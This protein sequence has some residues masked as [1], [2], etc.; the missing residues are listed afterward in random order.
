MNIEFTKRYN[1]SFNK[2][3]SNYNEKSAGIGHY[4]IPMIILIVILQIMEVVEFISIDFKTVLIVYL[5]LIS[6]YFS[7]NIW[8]KNNIIYQTSKYA[9]Y[10]IYIPFIVYLI[11]S[12]IS[13]NILVKHVDMNLSEI[14]KISYYTMAALSVIIIFYAIGNKSNIEKAF[15]NIHYRLSII[16]L[17]YLYNLDY[18]CLDEFDEKCVLVEKM[19]VTCLEIKQLYT[20]KELEL[21]NKILDDVKLLIA[22]KKK[23]KDI[24][25]YIDWLRKELVNQTKVV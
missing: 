8:I 7:I 14:L 15:A 11:V 10:I 24:D 18:E 13:A 21:I 1:D 4:F 17:N 3:T 12:V 22:N 25:K 2:I 16:C 19:S 23:L 9:K 5:T 6:F 20:E